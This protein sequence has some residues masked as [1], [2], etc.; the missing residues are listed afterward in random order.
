MFGNSN[1][2]LPAA[3][4]IFYQ[5]YLTCQSKIRGQLEKGILV[6]TT[7]ELKLIYIDSLCKLQDFT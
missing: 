3:Y 1:I 2:A 5:M 4:F 6:R 7:P